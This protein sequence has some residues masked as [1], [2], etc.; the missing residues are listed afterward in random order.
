M[1]GTNNSFHFKENNNKYVEAVCQL[2]CDWLLELPLCSADL[3][4]SRSGVFTAWCQNVNVKNSEH[5]SQKTQQTR[6]SFG[7]ELDFYFVTFATTKIG[8]IGVTITQGKIN[9]IAVDSRLLKIHFILSVLAAW[10][11]H[12]AHCQREKYERY[13]HIN[14]HRLRGAMLLF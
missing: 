14:Q 3:I 6:A 5:I 12:T 13:H 4:A 8:F 9:K 2:Y 7:S 10:F 1:A 11:L